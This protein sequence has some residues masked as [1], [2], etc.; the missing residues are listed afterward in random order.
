MSCRVWYD[1]DQQPYYELTCDDCGAQFTCYDD[2]CYDWPL[3]CRAAMYTGWDTHHGRPDGP[4]HC[5]TCQRTDRNEHAG[6]RA[7]PN[8]DAVTDRDLRAQH[9]P[10]AR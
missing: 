5:P 3:L 1:Q 4:H 10:P 9:R 7:A 6:Q 2:S 8:Q